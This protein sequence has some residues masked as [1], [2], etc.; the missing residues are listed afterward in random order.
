MQCP[1]C[2]EQQL[3][4]KDSN[5]GIKVMIGGKYVEASFRQPGVLA[6]VSCGYATITEYGCRVYWKA[7]YKLIDQYWRALLTKT[8]GA[9]ATK[10]LLDLKKKLRTVKFAVGIKRN[11]DTGDFGFWML[12]IKSNQ[13]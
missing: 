12:H 2:K 3:L 10:S 1:N 5:P 8:I 9:K 13:S 6:C 11:G 7:V 4:R